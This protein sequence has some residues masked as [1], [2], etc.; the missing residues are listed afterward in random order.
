MKA[1]AGYVMAD[2]N[3]VIGNAAG[4]PAGDTGV[5]ELG[6]GLN[7]SYQGFTVGGGV[8]RRIASVN[9]SAAATD[10]FVWNAGVMYAEG[11]YKVSLNYVNSTVEGSHAASGH[12][13]VDI[14]RVG[15][16]YDLGPGVILFS[17]LAYSDAQDESGND[18]LGNE[19]AY[20]GVVGLH[21][22]F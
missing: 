1:S 20:G 4:H 19:G 16:S 17:E 2:D 21:L 11:P 13:E 15:G 10:G 3:S 22:N 6:G 9:T 5:Q 12:D 18:A 7:L 8:K 14:W